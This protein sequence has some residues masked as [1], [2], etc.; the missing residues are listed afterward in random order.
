M[1]F[2]NLQKSLNTPQQISICNNK[3]ATTKRIFSTFQNTGKQ[4]DLQ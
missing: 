4:N 3:M 1:A 2:R